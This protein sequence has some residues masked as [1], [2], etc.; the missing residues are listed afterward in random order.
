MGIPAAMAGKLTHRVALE[1]VRL[2]FCSTL[3]SHNWPE[4][5]ASGGRQIT[6][7]KTSR[8]QRSQSQISPVNYLHIKS[9][10][11]YIYGLWTAFVCFDSPGIETPPSGT[12]SHTASPSAKLNRQRRG[13]EQLNSCNEA[14]VS[15]ALLQALTQLCAN[16]L[17]D[18]SESFGNVLWDFFL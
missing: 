13:H 3:C 7:S 8:T 14:L 1:M 2:N 6:H 4:P 12:R 9:V 15:G 10:C 11:K 16:R 5:L 18:S 17:L